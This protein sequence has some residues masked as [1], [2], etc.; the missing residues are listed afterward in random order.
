M[1]GHNLEALLSF[2]REIPSIQ[3][4]FNEVAFN[5]SP[6]EAYDIAQ[7]YLKKNLKRFSSKKNKTNNLLK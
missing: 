1:R 2:M 3:R 5:D 6:A 4:R 7:W